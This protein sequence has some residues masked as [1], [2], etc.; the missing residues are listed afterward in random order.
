MAEMEHKMDF[1]ALVSA[2][3]QVHEHLAVQA[4][5]AVNIS[6][7][8]RNLAIGCYIREYEQNGADRAKYG[9]S[10]LDDL[11]ERLQNDGM[12]RVAARELRRYRQFYLVYPQIWQSA[13]TEFRNMLPH[14]LL[15]EYRPAQHLRQLVPQ[16]GNGQRRQP[17]DWHPAVHTKG[18]CFGRVRPRRHG[19]Q[20]VRLQV[21]A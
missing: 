14:A 16:E 9:E 10:L 11:A 21:P 2:I 17:A 3:R 5:R 6:L 12:K 8:M 18:P 1:D 15:R 19:Q 4:S 20:P 13:T 7:T